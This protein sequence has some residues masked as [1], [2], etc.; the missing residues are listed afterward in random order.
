MGKQHNEDF[1]DLYSLSTIVRVIKWRRL[2]WA[3]HVACTGETTG[4][5]RVL[6]GKPEGQK[7]LG[8]SRHRWKMIL[9]CI[10]RK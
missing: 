6:V 4:L 9:R 7:L 10:F 8:R 5:Y 3:G 1:N 2:G